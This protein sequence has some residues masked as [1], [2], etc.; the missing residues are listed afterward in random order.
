MLVFTKLGMVPLNSLSSVL[1]GIGTF[2]VRQALIRIAP[3]SFP[4]PS[5]QSGHHLRPVSTKPFFLT[6]VKRETDVRK[7]IGLVDIDFLTGQR[8]RLVPFR[9]TDG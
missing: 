8:T 3:L 5:L 4:L 9:P 1:S 7:K 2:V 6:Y